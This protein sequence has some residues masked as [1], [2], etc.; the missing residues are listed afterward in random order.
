[1]NA[2]VRLIWHCP[3]REFPSIQA[4]VS[5]RGIVLEVCLGDQGDA[6]DRP[7][8]PHSARLSPF[9]GVLCGGASGVL[10]EDVPSAHVTGPMLSI[11][12]IKN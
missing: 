7:V 2:P 11:W 1:M 8:E 5:L 9:Q 10:Q 4:P 12:R 3:H 6:I